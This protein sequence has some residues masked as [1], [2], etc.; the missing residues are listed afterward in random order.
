MDSKR[1]KTSEIIRPHYKVPHELTLTCILPPLVA[2]RLSVLCSRE[3]YLVIM[4][5]LSCTDVAAELTESL[6]ELFDIFCPSAF[7]FSSSIPA[8]K[9]NRK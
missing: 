5:M 3:K 2:P 7:S 4:D 9:E 8:L 1:N 6:L